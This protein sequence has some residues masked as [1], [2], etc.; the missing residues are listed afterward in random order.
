MNDRTDRVAER[1]QSRRPSDTELL[2]G[3]TADSDVVL[4]QQH[5]SDPAGT[6]AD[7]SSW[8]GGVHPEDAR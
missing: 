5:L 4:L 2:L 7:S 3:P 8:L 6:L 1:A